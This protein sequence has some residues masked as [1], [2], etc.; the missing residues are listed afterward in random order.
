MMAIL[1]HILNVDEE[2][3]VMVA[4]GD[5]VADIQPIGRLQTVQVEVEPETGAQEE[6]QV[7]DTEEVKEDQEEVKDQ[8]ETVE[9][10]KQED[11]EADRVIEE[12]EPPAAA[13][14]AG[15]P[16]DSPKR[17]EE[18]IQALTTPT[19]TVPSLSSGVPSPQS[20]ASSGHTPKLEMTPMLPNTA[21]AEA[22]GEAARKAAVSSKKKASKTKPLSV[23]DLMPLHQDVGKS[24]R[25]LAEPA[26]P[27]FKPTPEWVSLDM[28]VSMHIKYKPTFNAR[29]TS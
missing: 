7:Q 24:T 2:E 6:P 27:D 13:A 15:N 14:K 17:T 5:R 26:T 12:E 20:R 18:P 16:S 25:Q 29:G 11:E 4:S 22:L 9:A 10:L 28:F 21:V 19:S 3:T 1:Y 23:K 8:E